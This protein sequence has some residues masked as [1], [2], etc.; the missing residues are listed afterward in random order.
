LNVE[1]SF[2]KQLAFDEARVYEVEEIKDVQKRGETWTLL[3]TRQESTKLKRLRTCKRE[4]YMNDNM[5]ESKR[6]SLQ[7]Y[8][9]F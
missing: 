8:L 1:L 2:E 4:A 9:Q 5:A 6:D 7:Q 3:S